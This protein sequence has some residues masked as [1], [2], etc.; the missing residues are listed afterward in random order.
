MIVFTDGEVRFFPVSPVPSS[1]QNSTS[2]KPSKTKILKEI[3][4]VH[5]WSSAL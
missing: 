5:A 2:L 1:P 4:F 3:Q